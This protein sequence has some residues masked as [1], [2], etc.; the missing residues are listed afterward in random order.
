MSDIEH[1]Y[2]R[3]QDRGEPRSEE[4]ILPLLYKHLSNREP[5]Q[6]SELT[7]F[8]GAYLSRKHPHLKE[9]FLNRRTQEE[10]ERILHVLETNEDMHA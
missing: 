2:L 9:Y 10:L 5:F 7:S 3:L 1:I 8:F 4:I 6:S